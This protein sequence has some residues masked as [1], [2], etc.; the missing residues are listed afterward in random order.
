MTGQLSIKFQIPLIRGEARTGPQGARN[1]TQ[2]RDPGLASLATRCTDPRARIVHPGVLN[3]VGPGC[4][5]R[6]PED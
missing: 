4:R 5:D 3:F 2:T 6:H 1:G